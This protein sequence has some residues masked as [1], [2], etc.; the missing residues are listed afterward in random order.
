MYTY[1]LIFE[2][3][4]LAQKT[5]MITKEELRKKW[6]ETNLDDYSLSENEQNAVFEWFWS[7]M[8]EGRETPKE[9]NERL[10]K[11]VKDI[12]KNAGE[13]AFS[14]P[15]ERRVPEIS[16][17]MGDLR[18]E[19]SMNRIECAKVLLDAIKHLTEQEGK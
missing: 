19:I 4:K 15:T 10:E 13:W 5:N 1:S 9:F 7:E 18:H 2:L 8:R 16:E 12:L 3:A 14:H 11:E 6:M 17:L